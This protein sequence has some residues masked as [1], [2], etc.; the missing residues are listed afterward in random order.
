VLGENYTGQLL[1]KLSG[2]FGILERFPKALMV[3]P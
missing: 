3:A 2:V 1:Q